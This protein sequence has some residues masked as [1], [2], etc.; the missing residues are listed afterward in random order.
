LYG[1]SSCSPGESCDVAELEPE[2][3]LSFLRFRFLSS[4]SH[5][6]FALSFLLFFRLLLCSL[7]RLCGVGN[8][9][10]RWAGRTAWYGK[11]G[12]VDKKMGQ[13]QLH[14]KTETQKS[15]SKDLFYTSPTLKNSGHPAYQEDRQ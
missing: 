9:K 6:P 11:K 7:N 4:L 10:Y 3:S 14:T 12:K 15:T 2:L 8:G 1:K 5:F 13:V